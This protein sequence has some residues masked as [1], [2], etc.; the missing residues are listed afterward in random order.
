MYKEVANDGRIAIIHEEEK[1]EK[2]KKMIS[3]F[4]CENKANK[5]WTKKPLK[6]C[7]EVPQSKLYTLQQV[8]F[9]PGCKLSLSLSYTK[10]NKHCLV[11][12]EIKINS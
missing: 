7:K 6:M 9:I 5:N 12:L 11:V 4:R 3:R 2:K 1:V 8:N 10:I